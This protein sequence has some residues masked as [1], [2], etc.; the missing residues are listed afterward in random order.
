[1]K[2]GLFIVSVCAISGAAILGCSAAV[3]PSLAGGVDAAS[4]AD[5][6]DA[7]SGK[8]APLTNMAAPTVQLVHAAT[9]L[10][11]VRI[12]FLPDADPAEPPDVTIPQTN[13]AGLPVGGA[14]FFR[15]ASQDS[16]MMLGKTFSPTARGARPAP[17]RAT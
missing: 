2:H 5:V 4:G 16:G 11:D 3:G 15:K 12:C 13:Y 1:M 14:P 8:T 10:G 7:D 17:N 6:P 9:G